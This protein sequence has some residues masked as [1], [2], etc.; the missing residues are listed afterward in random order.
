VEVI[1]FSLGLVW[2]YFFNF[3]ER[4]KFTIFFVFVKQD[5]IRDGY[6]IVMVDGFYGGLDG[7][8]E[9]GATPRNKP[10]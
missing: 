8:M 6:W 9:K 10:Q 4:D 2:G 1:L 3:Y 7:F 5:F